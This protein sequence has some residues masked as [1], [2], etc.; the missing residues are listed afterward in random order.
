MNNPI[1]TE[2]SY[3]DKDVFLCNDA[4]LLCATK[5]PNS[6]C[7]LVCREGELKLYINEISLE[8]HPQELTFVPLRADV[9]LKVEQSLDCRCGI[10]ACSGE[11]MKRTFEFNTALRDIALYLRSHPV[12][13]LPLDIQFT[14]SIMALF[15]LASEQNTYRT[16]MI[17]SITQYLLY[18]I[19]GHIEDMAGVQ[20]S[21]ALTRGEMLFMKFLSLISKH[22]REEREVSFYADKLFISPKYLSALCKKISKKSAST[23]I[24]EAVMEDIKHLLLHSELSVKEISSEMNFPNLSFFGRYVKK[25]LGLSPLAYRKSNF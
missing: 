12:V 1:K 9:Q 18:Y 22:H 11:L 24:H 2:K 14:S 3:Q 13:P 8:L 7:I 5:L 20:D 21:D 23:W 4:E 6:L 15:R 10:I 19:V 17:Q 16:Q 25:N